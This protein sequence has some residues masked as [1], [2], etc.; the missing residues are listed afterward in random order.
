MQLPSFR[1]CFN[2]IKISS[3]EINEERKR[4]N[5]SDRDFS[6]GS[7][8][9]ERRNF[10]AKRFIELGIKVD[11][12]ESND[13]TYNE[14]KKLQK[15][16][17]NEFQLKFKSDPNPFYPCFS[18]DKEFIKQKI[19]LKANTF[20]K[21]LIPSNNL[22]FSQI[23]SM[24]F[25]F[26]DDQVHLPSILNF[27]LNYRDSSVISV[28]KST[29]KYLENP[30]KSQCSYYDKYQNLFD[31]VSHKDCRLKCLRYLCY[32]KYKC[33]FLH[34]GYII[35]ES[36]KFRMD[37]IDLKCN[38][39][40]IKDCQSDEQIERCEIICPID[41]FKEEYHF[42]QV[43]TSK[44]REENTTERV[45]YF[46]WDSTQI[47]VSY[48]ET[49]DML[50][51]DYFTYIGGLFGLWFGICLE[52]LIDLILNHTK[53]LR[54]KIKN[55]FK[56]LISFIRIIS[57]SIFFW[58]YDLITILINSVHNY[59]VSIVGKIGFFWL[60]FCDCFEIIIDLIVTHASILKFKL[61]LYVKTFFS[62]IVILIKLLFVCFLKCILG[63]IKII[64]NILLKMFQSIQNRIETINI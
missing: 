16:V 20:M 1:I 47:F 32:A 4:L 12:Y 18:Y 53:T 55:Q 23:S 21:I 27:P 43:R 57:I 41:C 64:N 63:L 44:I 35:S 37:V 45:L 30:Y 14:W 36:D 31:S 25:E 11:F 26:I 34:D 33:F 7:L 62:F 5:K 13:E 17:V 8:L 42:S 6:F 29:E 50:L 58:I 28:V 9:F 60:W 46:Y 51:L 10:I 61:K 59:V 19:W 2:E 39:N 48:E 49:P 38:E 56:N 15:N 3:L 24:L 40:Q 52:K 54:S 22:I